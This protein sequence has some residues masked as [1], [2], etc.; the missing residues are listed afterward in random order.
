MGYVS[1]VGETHPAEG[2]WPTLPENTAR[3]QR[4]TWTEKLTSVHEV[5]EIVRAFVEGHFFH[6][7]SWKIL[8]NP[9]Q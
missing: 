3:W 8:G 1:I 2:E 5:C 6:T 7:A 9:P 4:H